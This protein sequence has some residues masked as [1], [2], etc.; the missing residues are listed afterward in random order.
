MRPDERDAALLWDILRHAREVVVFLADQTL[1]TYRSD[2]LMRRGV[3][4]S[5]S[6]VGEAAWRLSAEFKAAHPEVPWRAIAAQ[7]HILVHEYRSIDDEK[8]WRVATVHVPE[9]LRVIEPLVPEPPVGS[10][11]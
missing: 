1:E 9:L 5:V 7:R 3:E 4:R 10:E 2:L 8:I 11:G 6:I